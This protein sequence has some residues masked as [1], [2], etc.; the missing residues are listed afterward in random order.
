M[1]LGYQRRDAA[2]VDYELWRPGPDGDWL[3]GPRPPSLEPGSY[4]ACVG[5]AQTFGCFAARPWPA[6]LA[7]HV[8]LP[9]LNLGVAGAGPAL[10]RQPAFAPLLA[11]ARFVVF[12]VM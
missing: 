4:F 9:A 3:R 6:L 10:F 8:G 7:E 2:I 11:A 1:S 12:Q 5:G